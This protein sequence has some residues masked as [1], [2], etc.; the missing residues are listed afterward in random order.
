MVFVIEFILGLT[1]LE[2]FGLPFFSVAVCLMLAG[3]LMAAARYGL[4]QLRWPQRNEGFLHDPDGARLGATVGTVHLVGLPGALSFLLWAL[5]ERQR[6]TMLTAGIIAVAVL[7]LA[8]VIAYASRR[9]Q[10]R[11]L[12]ARGRE[13]L[14]NDPFPL[15]PCPTSTAP[16]TTRKTHGWK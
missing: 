15:D 16:A 10:T 9:R 3:F 6:V 1:P 7:L 14:L 12:Q 2:W 5:L 13:L 4:I 11:V 8:A